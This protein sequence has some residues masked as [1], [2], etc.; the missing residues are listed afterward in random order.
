MAMVVGM[1]AL[2]DDDDEDVLD[3]PS[4]DSRFNP[5][6]SFGLREAGFHYR[7]PKLRPL[8][9]AYAVRLSNE[10]CDCL[11]YKVVKCLRQIE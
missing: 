4:L 7:M 10:E 2:D 9:D 3:V 1:I 11:S 5:S 8:I 6:K